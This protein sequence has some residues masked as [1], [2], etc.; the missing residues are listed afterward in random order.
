[1][2]ILGNLGELNG[3]NVTGAVDGVLEIEERRSGYKGTGVPREKLDVEGIPAD[4]PSAM[5]F[6]SGF[7]GNQAPEDKVTIVGKR[8]FRRDDAARL[9]TPARLRAVVRAG[10][11][12]QS[13]AHVQSG[14]RQ[15]AGR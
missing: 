8:F 10:G 15:S 14:T 3:V 2:S 12:N 5:G 9:P 11:R 7:R 13:G 4:S 1:V 6:K